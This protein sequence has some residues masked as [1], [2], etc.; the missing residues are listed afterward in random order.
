[1]ATTLADLIT[2]CRA[3]IL[4]DVGV[5]IIDEDLR[6]QDSGDNLLY[7]SKFND[8]Q[9]EP[10]PRIR[11]ISSGGVETRLF[12]TTD[13]TLNLPDG[14]VTLVAPLTAGDVLR[15]DYF[16]MPLSDAV[17]LNIF[18]DSLKEVSVLIHR[19]VD[20]ADIHQDYQPAICKR[21]YTNV[22]KTL[23][24]ESRN[25]FSLSVAGRSINK[26]DIPKNIDLIIKMNEAQLLQDLNQLRYFN[27]TNRLS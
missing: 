16:F 14:E 13:Y 7:E 4:S 18:G 26:A 19:L 1:M 5:E 21:A 17:L 25:F 6:Q 3:S 23:L 24:V 27:K 22:L 9:A 8:W 2:E 10:K 20:S 15:A 12:E 11:I